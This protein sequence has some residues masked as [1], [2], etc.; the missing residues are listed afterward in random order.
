MQGFQNWKTIA[1]TISENEVSKQHMLFMYT[2]YKRSSCINRIDTN[3]LQITAHEES[4]WKEVLKRVVSIIKLL[5]RLGLAFRG[6]EEVQHSNGKGNY[7]TFR[8]T[9]VNMIIF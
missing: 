3:L 1:K 2:F 5:S 4:Y 8:N 9:L 7:L 6:H